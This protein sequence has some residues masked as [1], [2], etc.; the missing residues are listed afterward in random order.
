M[1][2]GGGKG[3]CL[4]PASY[5]GP[6]PSHPTAQSRGLEST[7][8]GARQTNSFPIAEKVGGGSA[9]Q[10]QVVVKK[11]YLGAGGKEGRQ[12]QGRDSSKAISHPPPVSPN[13]YLQ[14]MPGLVTLAG[15]VCADPISGSAQNRWS[16]CSHL[17]WSAARSAQIAAGCSAGLQRPPCSVGPRG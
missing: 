10:N 8:R 14:G 3:G 7:H 2:S 12:G 17:A 9:D 1:I 15:W 6:W 4:G 16:Q 13:K 5:P 11:K